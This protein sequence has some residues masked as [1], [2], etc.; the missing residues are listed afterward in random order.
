[1]LVA[2]LF[3]FN[4][5]MNTPDGGTGPSGSDGASVAA[6]GVGIRM[7][8]WSERTAVR[9]VR[10]EQSRVEGGSGGPQ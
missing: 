10:S 5:D 7:Q 3:L 9:V 2:H 1:M 4:A 8:A 6:L